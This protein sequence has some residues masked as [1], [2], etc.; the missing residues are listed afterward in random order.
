MRTRIQVVAL[1]GAVLV[2]SGCKKSGTEPKACLDCVAGQ[3]AAAG[4]ALE[5]GDYAGANAHFLEA[6]TNDRRETWSDH[7]SATHR[8]A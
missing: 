4:A 2:L 6:A 5:N 3:L 8:H 7:S 1:L